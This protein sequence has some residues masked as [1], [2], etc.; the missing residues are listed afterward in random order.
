MDA[1]IVHRD[2]QLLEALRDRCLAP[3]QAAAKGSRQ[4]FRDTLRSWL[5]H[6][7][8]RRAVADELQVH[9]QTVRYRMGRL[10]ELFGPVLSDPDGR[11]RLLLALAWEGQRD[12]PSADRAPE[13]SQSTTHR[14][15]VAATVHGLPRRRT[16][17]R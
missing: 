7:G 5:V 11:L 1:V 4:A 17:R 2:E 6:M 12:D 8:D 13:R 14:P 15:P 10:H 3:L 16:A 9:P